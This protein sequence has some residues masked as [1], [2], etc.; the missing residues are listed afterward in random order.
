[1][2][3]SQKLESFEKLIDRQLASVASQKEEHVDR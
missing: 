1:M 3:G 2:D